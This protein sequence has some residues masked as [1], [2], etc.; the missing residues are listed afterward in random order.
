MILTNTNDGSEL[1]QGKESKICEFNS[2]RDVYGSDHWYRTFKID[3]DFWKNGVTGFFPTHIDPIGNITVTQGE[4]VKVH[5]S[6]KRENWF[7]DWGVMHKFFFDTPAG[8]DLRI[9]IYDANQKYYDVTFSKYWDP[10]DIWV[11]ELDTSNMKP[12]KYVI[13]VTSDGNNWEHGAFNEGSACQ[14]GYLIIN[15]KT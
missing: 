1:V 12:G 15:P 11:P 13:Q 8:S 10:F 5:T 3:L 14:Y 2:S 9:R 7:Y 4:P 6:Y